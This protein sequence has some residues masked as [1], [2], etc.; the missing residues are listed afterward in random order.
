MEKG[1]I[2]NFKKVEAEKKEQEPTKEELLKE[3]EA[4]FVFAHGEPDL[5]KLAMDAKIRALAALEMVSEMPSLKK[6]YFVGGKSEKE[7]MKSTSEQMKDYFL[8]AGKKELKDKKIAV[9]ALSKS[10]NT[11]ANIKEIIEAIDKEK[12]EKAVMLSSNFQL[13]KINKIFQRLKVKPIEFSAE[14]LVATRSRR[15]GDLIKRH[16]S[17]LS[18]QKMALI[19]KAGILYMKLDPEY[20]LAAKWRTL[21]RGKL[22]RSN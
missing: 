1:P 12:L 5:K 13:P 11:V 14:E 10:N 9:E 22:S 15:H 21:R 19:H 2:L 20:R 7:E 6:I 3:T 8:K 18:Y 16:L 4:I 17:S